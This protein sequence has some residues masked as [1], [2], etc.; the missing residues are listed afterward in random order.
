MC[1]STPFLIALLLLAFSGFSQYPFQALTSEV[2]VDTTILGLNENFLAD[3]GTGV[4]TIDFNQDGF[5]DIVLGTGED[6]QSLWWVNNG[7]GTFTQ[8]ESPVD[9]DLFHKMILFG[10]IDNDGDPDLFISEFFG[11]CRLYRNNG[12]LDFQDITDWAGIIQN[13]EKYYGAS[14]GDVNN[15]GFL[16]LYVCNRRDKT[17]GNLLYINNGDLTFSEEALARGVGD[18]VQLSHQSL[19]FDYDNDG[20]QD[21]FVANDRLSRNSMYE[22]DGNGYFSNVTMTSGLGFIMDAMNAGTGDINYDGYEDLYVTNTPGGTGDLGVGSSRFFLNNGDGTFSEISEDI[23]LD[24]EKYS[25]AGLWMDIDND[26]DEDIFV[27]TLRDNS[28]FVIHKNFFEEYGLQLFLN[29]YPEGLPEGEQK[30]FSAAYFDFNNDGRLDVITPNAWQSPV[31]VW[32]NIVQN[33]YN[34]IEF[35]LE[36]EY[37]TRDGVGTRIILHIG[38]DVYYRSMK[39]GDAYL[40]QNYGKLHFGLGSA[41][42]VDSIEVLWLSGVTDTYYDLSANQS[43][44]LVEGGSYDLNIARNATGVS[45]FGSSD[46][47]V[48][49]VPQNGTAPYTYLW[50]NGEQTAM[51]DNLPG[52]RYIVTVTDATGQQGVLL[53]DLPEPDDVAI[54]IQSA[55]QNDMQQGWALAQVQGGTPPYSYLWDSGHTTDLADP[56][57]AGMYSVQ[58]QD[59]RGCQ[60]NALAAVYDEMESCPIALVTDVTPSATSARLFWGDLP[61]LLDMLIAYRVAGT[62]DWSYLTTTDATFGIIDDLLIVYNLRIQNLDPVYEW[63]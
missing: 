28:S 15:D 63:Q 10:D 26:R 20:D 1:K 57:S 45:C 41:T 55:N 19:F 40:T 13:D 43:V 18:N 60:R 34:Y 12:D 61:N 4:S 46:G 44:H 24:L 58:V 33:E 7:D 16:D 48:T 8:I 3:F 14:F 17:K 36:G 2:G 11:S 23:G 56:L 31:Q 50:N 39:M 42:M 37:S 6:Q 62:T 5:S 21:L 59:N 22:N 49:A 25:W 30:S 51:I 52:G 27:A 54:A 53:V 9:N 38:E 32:E 47:S 35:S 29:P